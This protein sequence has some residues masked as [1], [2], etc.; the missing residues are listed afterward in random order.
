[1]L[2]NINKKVLSLFIIIV[3]INGIFNATFQL[4]YDESYYWVWS[5][6]LALS[7]FDHSPMIAYMIALTTYFN[8]SEFFVRLPALITTSI[9]ALTIFALAKRMFN[10]RVANIALLLA[11]SWPM[12]EGNFFIVTPDC[13]LNMFWALTLLAFYIGIFENKPRHIYLAG[14]FAG[15]AL[16]SKYTAILIFPGLFLFLV[17][18]PDMR[19]YLWRKEVYFAFIISLLVFT[20]VIIWNY[21]HHWV[22]L[23][24]Q[25]KHG[26]DDIQHFRLSSFGDFLSAQIGVANPIIMLS[27]FYY[28]IRYHKIHLTNAKLAFLFWP[29]IFCMLFFTHSSFYTYV[30]ANWTEPGIISG[31]IILAYWLDYFHNKWIY[32]SSLCLIMLAILMVKLPTIFL[33]APLVKRIAAIRVFYANRELVAQIKPMLHD[34]TVLLACD[35]GNASRA[36]Y[37]VNDT[38]L[39]TNQPGYHQVYVLNQFRY[40]NAYQYWNHDL[41]MPIKHAI[42]VCDVN[43][44]IDISIL[45]KY[46]ANV[47]L[48]KTA[49]VVTA[50]HQKRIMYIFSADN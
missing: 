12:L 10:A 17:F 43:D 27:L 11:I 4:H 50:L 14:F 16:L 40:A 23:F 7:Y 1:M 47:Q 20:P 25:L 5:Q 38:H 45:K 2:A 41:T 34:D 18:N 42:F 15:G 48:L 39:N 9:T 35:Y 31:I 3:V 24:F 32:R 29:F 30:G 33:P 6:H 13:P 8:H 19:Q 28:L 36:W 37:Y 22:S 21:Q 26:Y 44:A 46:F 49:T